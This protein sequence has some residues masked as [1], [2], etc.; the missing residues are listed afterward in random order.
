MHNENI[1]H[2]FIVSDNKRVVTV[3]M[4]YMGMSRRAMHIMND[5]VDRWEKLGYD[6]KVYETSNEAE[7][8]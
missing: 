8:K 2:F 5:D 1:N 6:V 7:I 3:S 4:I